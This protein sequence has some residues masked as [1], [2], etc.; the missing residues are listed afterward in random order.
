MPVAKKFFLELFGR[1]GLHYCHLSFPK[2]RCIL[3]TV[4]FEKDSQNTLLFRR[5]LLQHVECF[6]QWF[7]QTLTVFD[8]HSLFFKCHFCFSGSQLHLPDVHCLKKLC[9]VEEI[10][11]S[12]R[13][14]TSYV[15]LQHGKIIH[16]PSKNSWRYQNSLQ[17]CLF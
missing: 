17:S 15:F 6:F 8:I 12:S 10:I 14:I 4:S 3:E 2:L 7:L 9:T 13:Y 5:S 16:L 11:S 1:D